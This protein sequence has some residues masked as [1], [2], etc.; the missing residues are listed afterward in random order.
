[1]TNDGKLIMTNSEQ[2]LREHGFKTTLADM[3][4]CGFIGKVNRKAFYKR[5]VQLSAMRLGDTSITWPRDEDTKELADSFA[6]FGD[7][8]D[9]RT[10]A[11]MFSTISNLHNEQNYSRS[12]AAWLNG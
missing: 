11:A 5:M 12:L 6:F 1:M 10:Q 9:L 8:N 3:A 7:I 4:L 2:Q